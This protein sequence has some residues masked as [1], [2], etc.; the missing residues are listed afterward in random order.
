MSDEKH[1]PGLM[2]MEDAKY[3]PRTKPEKSW[4][5]KAKEAYANGA[6]DDEVCAVIGITRTEFNKMYQ[7]IEPFKDLV[8]Y[9]RVA[10]KAYWY[11]LARKYV[12]EERDKP[13]LN[14]ATWQF[15]MKNVYGWG[16]KADAGLSPDAQSL[17]ELETK[18]R[19]VMPKMLKKL[20]VP[21]LAGM[22]INNDQVN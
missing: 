13:K 1:V 16:D 8:D 9:G 2:G 4:P 10:S 3:T 12:I 11:G 15:V 14:A 5:D 20:N 17:E 21:M 18:L 6:F 22:A 19:A 7:D